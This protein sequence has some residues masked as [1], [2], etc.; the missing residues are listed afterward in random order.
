MQRASCFVEPIMIRT[1]GRSYSSPLPLPSVAFEIVPLAPADI[2]AQPKEI[3]PSYFDD[4][5]P[6]ELKLHI[7][8][9]LLGLFEVEFENRVASGKWTAHKASSSRSKWVGRD[10][11]V[12]ELFK[13]SRVS[14]AWRQLV[15]D[16]QLWARLDLRAFPKLPVPVLAQLAQTAGG[17]VRGLDLSG[18]GA[19]SLAAFMDLSRHLA[20]QSA[21]GGRSH[22]NLTSI[23][24]QGCYALTPD[25]LHGILFRSP[26]LKKLCLRGLSA[27]T[28]AICGVLETSCP[29][30]VVLDLGRCR[31]LT[32]EGIH[33]VTVKAVERKKTIPL[34]ELRLSG[35]RGITDG[36]MA[37]LGRA[38]PHLEVLDLSYTTVHNS[39]IEAFVTCT[40]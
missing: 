11:G 1:K 27:V 29:E 13:L 36:W 24:L 5:L 7:L 18:H 28:N 26:L 19:L 16:G 30:L 10:K 34:K 15:F 35:L 14:H 40:E 20:I 23:N 22:T 9:L 6:K 8:T 31:R 38:A 32:A 12:R 4:W 21:H 2:F 17:F 39:A 37:S 3:V 25:A 33:S